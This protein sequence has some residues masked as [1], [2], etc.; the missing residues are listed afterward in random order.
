MKRRGGFSVAA[1]VKAIQEERKKKKRVSEGPRDEKFELLERASVK[2]WTLKTSESGHDGATVSTVLRRGASALDIFL[3]V[4]STSM[5]KMLADSL[6]ITPKRWSKRLLFEMMAIYMTIQ[7]SLPRAQRGSEPRPLQSAFIVASSSLK[8]VASRNRLMSY[9]TWSRLMKQWCFSAS[10]V[11][12]KL[13]QVLEQLVDYGSVITLDEKLRAYGGS[14]CP[15]IITVPSK[16][17][18]AGLWV[19]QIGVVLHHTELPF[20]TRLFPN[21]ACTVVGER[22]PVSS[23]VDFASRDL[24]SQVDGTRPTLVMDARYLDK[25]GYDILKEREVSFLASVNPVWFQKLSQAARENVKTPGDWCVFRNEEQGELFVHF[26]SPVSRIGKR[27]LLTDAFEEQRT[28]LPSDTCPCW[29]TYQIVFGVLDRF[30]AKL[31]GHYWPFRRADWEMS[32]HDLVFSIVMVDVYHLYC[33]LHNQED[34]V[35]FVAFMKKLAIDLF[36]HSQTLD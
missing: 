5:L 25:A 26:Y 20:V 10:F 31:Y 30:N 9:N 17:D 4:F 12:E 16:P 22:T 3:S 32:L 15:C 27:F 18:G 34:G 21:T 11:K 8:I 29:D 6:P 19:S 13:S 7:F 28:K 1:K 14:N 35:A 33:E 23:I 2:N 36:K 24:P